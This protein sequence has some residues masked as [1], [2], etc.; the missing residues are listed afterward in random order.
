LTRIT[1]FVVKKRKI[2]FMKKELKRF[3]EN[4]VP[5]TRKEE[6]KE[7]KKKEK[8][9]KSPNHFSLKITEVPRVG[10]PEATIVAYGICEDVDKRRS[11]NVIVVKELPIL[12]RQ[13]NNARLHKTLL[14]EPVPL[15]RRKKETCVGLGLLVWQSDLVAFHPFCGNFKRITILF[16]SHPDSVD[17]HACHQAQ[18]GLACHPPLA[19]DSIDC[20][21][22]I[23]IGQAF[24]RSLNH[25]TKPRVVRT[26]VIGYGIAYQS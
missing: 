25:A 2:F 18:E 12:G 11:P 13:A 9:K 3:R 1:D 24:V 6:K 19:V 10:S 5:K 7:K 26:G 15:V 17:T 22:R 4:K 20:N 14:L 16:G 23:S 8:E 21:R